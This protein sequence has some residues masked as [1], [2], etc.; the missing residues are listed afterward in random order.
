MKA[1]Y[2]A[3]FTDATRPVFGAARVS[4]FMQTAAVELPE[5]VK[6]SF[7]LAT[8]M[9]RMLAF[10]LDVTIQII[11]FIVFILFMIMLAGPIGISDGL[12]FLL[13]FVIFMSFAIFV[14]YFFVMEGL[15]AGRTLGKMALGLR[16]IREDGEEIGPARGIT[17]A[18]MRFLI[19]GPI[20][21]LL[22]FGVSSLEVLAATPF[23]LL[24]ALM[25]LDRQARGVPDFAAGTLVVRQSMPP[26]RLNRPYV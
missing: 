24:G 23:F 12:G 20:P 17:R 5:N 9:A 26:Y 22:A 4:S 19:I 2:R 13:A 7:E 1:S 3:N 16:V 21:V 18:F 25:F 11:A 6:A 15:F 14:G 10:L 8:P